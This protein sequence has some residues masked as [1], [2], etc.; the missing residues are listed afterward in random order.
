[1]LVPLFAMATAFTRFFVTMLLRMRAAIIDGKLRALRQIQLERR[2]RFVA[3]PCEAG[4][5]L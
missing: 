1:M 3:V 2:E 4:S 5:V